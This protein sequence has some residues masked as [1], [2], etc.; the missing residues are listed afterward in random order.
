M[1]DVKPRNST[2]TVPLSLGY[3]GGS[4]LELHT[5]TCI[6]FLKTKWVDYS[7]QPYAPK[8]PETHFLI[9]PHRLKYCE[10]SNTL[11]FSISWLRCT[12]RLVAFTFF[13]NV[14]TISTAMEVKTRS[15]NSD[16]LVTSSADNIDSSNTAK[17]SL[18]QV[19]KASQ[20]SVDYLSSKSKYVAAEER[21]WLTK[22]FGE[23]IHLERASEAAYTTLLDDAA[24]KLKT[25]LKIS[26]IGT[27]S[28]TENM[29]CH[30]SSA[31]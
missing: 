26:G 13:T 10:R 5:C 7:G 1:A 24:A 31:H 29:E 30:L 16:L 18:R 12:L 9:S 23:K 25:F 15:G 11:M 2:R 20:E 28:N 8:T 3:S 27:I 14:V 6:S 19:A 4:S 17:R 22:L 21:G